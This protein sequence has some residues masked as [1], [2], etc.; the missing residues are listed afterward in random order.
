VSTEWTALRIAPRGSSRQTPHDGLARTGGSRVPRA[1]RE[2]IE[3]DHVGATGR[4]VSPCG[5]AA[6]IQR[7]SSG[8]VRERRHTGAPGEAADHGEAGRDVNARSPCSVAS[9]LGTCEVACQTHA[10]PRGDRGMPDTR[11]ALE[12]ERVSSSTPRVVDSGRATQK[13]AQSL[14]RAWPRRA[15]RVASDEIRVQFSGQKRRADCTRAGQGPV[16]AEAARSGVARYVGP[17]GG[18]FRPS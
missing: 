2:D 10:M 4:P 13:F 11:P 9:A 14:P 18:R 8:R 1:G 5:R 3:L 17:A 6:A 12:P 15:R 16:R 7:S